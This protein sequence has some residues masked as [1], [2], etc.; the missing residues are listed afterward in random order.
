MQR[1]AQPSSSPS[2]EDAEK[3]RRCGMEHWGVTASEIEHLAV[4]GEGEFAIQHQ[5]SSNG[6]VNLENGQDDYGPLAGDRRSVCQ[7]V[8]LSIFRTKL[9]QKSTPAVGVIH[10]RLISC[11]PPYP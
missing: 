9:R 8:A 4:V 3:G 7:S 6:T 1:R 2:S 5:L 11:V 10:Q